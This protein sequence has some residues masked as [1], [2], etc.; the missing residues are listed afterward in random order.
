LSSA[1]Q[2]LTCSSCGHI[3][4]FG[5][6]FCGKCGTS[7]APATGISPP[8]TAPTRA[9]PVGP[10][11]PP[12]PAIPQ[13]PWR[14]VFGIMM[15]PGSVIQQQ[16]AD[17]AWPSAMVVSGLAF[18]LF[19]LQTGLDLSRAGKATA[20]TVFGL[21]VIGAI[22]GTIGIALVGVIAWAASKS[23]GG[24]K[25]MDWSIRAIS[26]SYSPTLVYAASGLL[27]NL[28]LGWNTAVAFGV[29]GVLW[30]LGPINA[31]VKEMVNGKTGPSIVLST[32]C[33]V[34]VLFAWAALGNMG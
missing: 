17:V 21:L 34:L 6:R 4:P 15:N 3:E 9:S 22:Y 18:T 10:T 20:G 14:A 31:A 32:I 25:P 2:G 23:L 1:S 19:F 11:T 30:A 24:S 12:K 33:G 8:T 26:L 28:F 13:L 7:L 5:Q 27:F 29:T 16:L